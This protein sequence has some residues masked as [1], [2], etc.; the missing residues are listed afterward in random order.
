MV[1]Y[2]RVS[3]GTPSANCQRGH[4]LCSSCSRL[5]HP[6]PPTAP[7]RS[8]GG[9]GST[10]GHTAVSHCSPNLVRVST[11][12]MTDPGLNGTDSHGAA[13]QRCPHAVPGCCPA[14]QGETTLLLPSSRSPPNNPTKQQCDPWVTETDHSGNTHHSMTAAAARG[15]QSPPSLSRGHELR[16]IPPAQQCVAQ[17]CSTGASLLQEHCWHLRHRRPAGLTVPRDRATQN[18]GCCRAGALAM[19]LCSQR[20]GG[21]AAF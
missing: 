1:Y 21:G 18:P 14:L 3:Q 4:T 5:P 16:P 2:G 7:Q 11:P 6:L 10:G 17:P 8:A 9:G 20:E 13:A 12:A 19:A 15:P